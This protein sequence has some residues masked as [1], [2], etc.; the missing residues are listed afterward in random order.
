MSRSLRNARAARAGFSMIEMMAVIVIILILMAFLL[1]RLGGMREAVQANATRAFLEGQVRAAIGQYENEF[2]APPAS[3]WDEK[4]GAQPNDTNLGSEILYLAIWSE[5]LQGLGM[6]EGRLH[7]TDQ[8]STIKS[9]TILGARELFELCD[10]WGNPIA[11][12]HH[13]D[14]G[15]ADRYKTFDVKTG[16]ELETMVRA[17]EDPR[18]KSYHNPRGYQ[19]ISA[20]EDGRFGTEDDITNFRVRD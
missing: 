10:D 14:Y 13:R 11:Y 16:E 7:N 19:L 12:F 4:W 18:T 6:D 3:A 8:D 20:G 9:F 2:G 15:R 17:R 5:T 1:P